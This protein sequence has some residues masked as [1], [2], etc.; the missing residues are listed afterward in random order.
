[1]NPLSIMFNFWALLNVFALIL[2][3]ISHRRLDYL[4]EFTAFFYSKNFF[5]FILKVIILFAYLPLNIASL[6][7]E[8]FNK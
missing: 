1:M 7:K 2:T 8:I 4:I 5:V 6:I 3:I